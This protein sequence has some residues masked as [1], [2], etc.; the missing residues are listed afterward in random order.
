M[1]DGGAPAPPA[2]VLSDEADDSGDGDDDDDADSGAPV[3]ANLTDGLVGVGPDARTADL[4]LFGLQVSRAVLNLRGSGM[5]FRDD[6]ARGAREWTPLEVVTERMELVIAALVA[7]DHW[8]SAHDRSD[9][10][11][12]EAPSRGGSPA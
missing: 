5:F 1:G 6:R 12:G 7:L 8:V 3:E 10:D 2:C 11:A 4:R 9:S